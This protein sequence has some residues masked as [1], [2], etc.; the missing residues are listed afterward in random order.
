MA[1]VNYALT[2]AEK[3]KGYL[4]LTGIDVARDMVIDNLVN[5]VSDFIESYCGGRRFLAT[6]YV[7]VKDTTQSRMIFMSQRPVNTVTVLEYRSGVPSS[8]TWTTYSADAYLK[9]LKAGY[10]RFFGMMSAFPQAFRITYNA[11]Y[12]IDWTAE[13]DATK[14]T[15]PFDLTQV[16]TEIVAKQFNTRFAQ[17]IVSES[18]EGQSVTYATKRES[19]SDYHSEIL[20][21]YKM[22]RI[23]P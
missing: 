7:E 5:A 13:T 2:T 1:T 18:T 4:N 23:I 19:L 10:I 16:A 8:P 12:L 21:K 9:Y 15:L 6:D 3:V 11:G 14:H 17:G 22:N 20:D